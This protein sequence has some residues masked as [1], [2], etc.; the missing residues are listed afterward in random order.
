MFVCDLFYVFGV[1]TQVDVNLTHRANEK[2][3][4]DDDCPQCIVLAVR[5]NCCQ[6]QTHILLL[7]Y[8]RKKIENKHKT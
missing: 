8:P 5:D 3:K 1:L 4:T 2:N 6:G 7:K